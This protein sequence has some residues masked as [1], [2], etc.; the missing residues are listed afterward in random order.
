MG[1]ANGFD[2]FLS[3]SSSDNAAVRL[4]AERLQVEEG[5]KPFLDSSHLSPGT[6][7]QDEIAEALSPRVPPSRC[8][9]DRLALGRGITKRCE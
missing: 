1:R 8:S 7:W 3:H 6:P 4:I 9:S 2:V 5:L